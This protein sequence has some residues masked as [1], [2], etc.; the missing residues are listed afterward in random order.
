MGRQNRSEV[1]I[2]KLLDAVAQRLL[3]TD[4]SLIRIPE[5]CQATG[6]NYGSVYHHFKNR[7]AVIDGA[8]AKLFR[9]FVDSDIEL[10]RQATEVPET[11]DTFGETIR[12]VIHLVSDTSVRNEARTMRLRII[13]MA[14]TRP[15]LMQ[16]IGEAQARLTKQL[17]A[18][19]EV[20]QKRG[21][22]PSNFPP[23]SMAV[24]IQAV[25]FGRALDNVSTEALSDADWIAMSEA[26]LLALI[27]PSTQSALAS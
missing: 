23:K 4:E 14:Q 10:L 8:Y 15:E 25:L 11:D 16:A 26:L 9:Q 3:T 19:V 7:D 17:A 1:T 12:A 2:S 27:V 20:A 5:V 13:A 18:V 21:F 24:A 22:I 6:V